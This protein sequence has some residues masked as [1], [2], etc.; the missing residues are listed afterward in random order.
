VL[1]FV[2]ASALKAIP[3]AFPDPLTLIVALVCFAVGF[4]V[5]RFMDVAEEKQ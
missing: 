2:I 3:S 4:F 1:G 5:A